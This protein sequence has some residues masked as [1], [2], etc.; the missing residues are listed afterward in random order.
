MKENNAAQA[1]EQ[2]LAHEIWAAAQTPPGDT[3]EAAVVRIVALLSKLRAEGVQAGDERPN[4]YEHFSDWLKKDGPI[5]REVT[6]AEMARH[7]WMAGMRFADLYPLASAPVAGERAALQRIVDTAK[8]GANSGDRHAR[9]VELARVALASAP[10]TASLP[11]ND[12]TDAAIRAA[13]TAVCGSS[14]GWGGRDGAFFISGYVAG[15][16][17]SAPVAGEEDHDAK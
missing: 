1:A 5:E 10:A 13:Y 12:E 9:C 14:D 8:D 7:G 4:E 15:H 16:R 2:D 11:M 3:I 6:K 17:A